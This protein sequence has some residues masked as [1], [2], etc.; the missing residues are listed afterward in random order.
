MLRIFFSPFICLFTRLLF[1][2]QVFKL[3]DETTF[4]LSFCYCLLFYSAGKKQPFVVSSASAAIGLL[5][6]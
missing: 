2:A 3:N 1:A 6:K 5:E 4:D